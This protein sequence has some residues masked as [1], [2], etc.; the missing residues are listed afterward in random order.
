M[1]SLFDDLS[2]RLMRDPRLTKKGGPRFDISLLLFNARDSVRV[3]WLLRLAL[4]RGDA[5]G[6]G[7]AAETLSGRDQAAGRERPAPRAADSGQSR[8]GASLLRAASASWD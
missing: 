7:E 1:S 8:G 5:L 6:A 4:V 3:L 2:E